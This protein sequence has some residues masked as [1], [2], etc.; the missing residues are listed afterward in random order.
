MDSGIPFAEKPSQSSSWRCRWCQSR[1]QTRLPNTRFQSIL[2]ALVARVPAKQEMKVPK[3]ES[4]PI[5]MVDRTF[6]ETWLGT[7][8]PIVC[9][10]YGSPNSGVNYY[11]IEGGYG[12]GEGDRILQKRKVTDETQGVSKRVM[13]TIMVSRGVAGELASPIIVEGRLNSWQQLF[14][15]V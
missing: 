13:G 5:L 12:P 3:A 4:G 15:R 9:A 8:K 1:A 6:F 10:S 11:W 14:S 7:P 2:T